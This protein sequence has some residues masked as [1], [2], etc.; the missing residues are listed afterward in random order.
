MF[1]INGDLMAM[2]FP[3]NNSRRPAMIFLLLLERAKMLQNLDE[4]R[5][6]SRQLDNPCPVN[7]TR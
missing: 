5:L 7:T 6:R 2:V 1:S 3:Y 4:I